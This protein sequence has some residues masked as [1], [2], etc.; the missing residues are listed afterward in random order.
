MTWHT[1]FFPWVMDTHVT[2]DYPEWGSSPRGPLVDADMAHRGELMA[3]V[4]GESVITP[5]KQ[6]VY[7]VVRCE[8]CIAT[9]IWPLPSESDLAAYYA[10]RFYVGPA[11]QEVAQHE[12]D[13]AWY[14]T[15]CY[16]PVL[17]QC[18]NILLTQDVTHIPR[19]L[20]IGAGSG[21]LLDTAQKQGWK[22]FG[23]EPD[24]EQCAELASRGHE[25]CIG[26][27]QDHARCVQRNAP[28]ILCLWETLEH[29]VCPEDTLLQCYDLMKPGALL[30]VSVPNDYSPLQLAACQKYRIAPWWLIPPVHLWHFTPKTAQLLIRRCGFTILD[31]R[32]T[33]PLEVRMLDDDGLCYV[34]NSTQWRE[35]TGR[36]NAFE[37]REM[38]AGR[39]HDLEDQYRANL[40]ERIGRSIICIAQKG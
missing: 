37:L 36:K 19:V 10:R 28:D 3:S 8:L 17:N 29:V 5:G 21:I 11:A 6:V 22:T 23:I 38:Q 33:Y 14:E 31:M 4:I 18:H 13:R 16:G 40:A 35:Y 39:W 9:H 1:N 25:P 7:H 32:G 26:T 24:T 34:G 20:D 15:C 27:L 2:D 12:R 30:V